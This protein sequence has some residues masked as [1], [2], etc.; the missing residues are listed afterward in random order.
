MVPPRTKTKAANLHKGLTKARIPKKKNCMKSDHKD[1]HFCR[2][3]AGY[4]EAAELFKEDVIQLSA[5]D[6]NKINV[7][8]LA[9][10]RYHW[11]S[12]FFLVLKM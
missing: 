6:K 1:L 3:K 2:A 4:F 9:V 5:D 10:S 7:G 11:I 8:T 12:K